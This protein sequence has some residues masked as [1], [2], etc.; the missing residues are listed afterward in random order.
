[1]RR[2]LT[3]P[4]FTAK[5]EKTREGKIRKRK[6]DSS[7]DCSRRLDKGRLPFKEPLNIRKNRFPLFT[8]D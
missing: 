8:G 1:M 4:S 2:K 6:T 5:N 3:F 7:T